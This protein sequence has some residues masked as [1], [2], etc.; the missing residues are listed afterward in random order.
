MAD[1][2]VHNVLQSSERSL[3]IEN[4]GLRRRMN[5][6]EISIEKHHR[7]E[8][9]AATHRE[10]IEK[11]D[12]I[13]SQT[14][15]AQSE[16]RLLKQLISE[17]KASKI[18]LVEA[19]ESHRLL[20]RDH[21]RA[22]AAGETYDLITTRLGKEYHKVRILEVTPLGV[23]ISHSNGSAR[24]GYRDMPDD[25]KTKFMFTAREVAV[26]TL[27]EQRRTSQERRKMA[28]RDRVIRKLRQ[29]QSRLNQIASLRKQIA[30][31][32]I[33]Y[34]TAKTEARLARA[35]LSYQESLRNSRVYARSSYR[36]R[37]YN[38]SSGRYY[39]SSY[40]PRYR[41][42]LNGSQ[43]VPGSLETWGQ[44]AMKYERLA[45]GYAAKLANLQSRLAELDPTYLP[46]A[47]EA[48]EG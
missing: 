24:L 31:V 17:V 28:E 44:R 11:I 27:D 47:P 36:Y 5:D 45:A 48:S 42:T 35:K 25:W 34:S 40:R 19:K 21:V 26:A 30:S 15:S 33:Q 7:N 37:Y 1:V 20:Y 3:G 22:S 46:P 38:T 12:A 14:S 43:S 10:Q 2:G 41:I 29:S 16:V 6:L 23:G 32:G 13:Q 8:V 18:L 9:V 39:Y 4:D